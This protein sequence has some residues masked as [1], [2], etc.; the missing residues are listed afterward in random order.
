MATFRRG[1]NC[2]AAV[3]ARSPAAPPP[4]IRRSCRRT[5]TMSGSLSGQ[6]PRKAPG[7]KGIR[8][9]APRGKKTAPGG[10]SNPAEPGGGG[11]RQ[12]ERGAGP[13]Q[14]PVVARRRRPEVQDHHQ[15]AVARVVEDRGH[16]QELDR[17]EPEP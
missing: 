7:W 8:I 13:E 15:D 4:M 12:V 6:G 9:S 1:Y 14:P 5:S 11:Q 17:L 10:Q 3:A 16:E 2:A